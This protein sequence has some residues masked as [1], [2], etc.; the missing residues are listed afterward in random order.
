LAERRAK[1]LHVIMK[2]NPAKKQHFVELISKILKNGH[3]EV[4]PELKPNEECWYIPIHSVCIIRKKLISVVF[5]SSANF[6]D[7]LL[8][9]VL[10][11]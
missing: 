10:M 9:D 4:A 7:L 5:D 8:N 11:S 6:Q 3:A 2:N 1:L